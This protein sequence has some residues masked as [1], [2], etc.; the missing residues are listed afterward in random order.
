[1]LALSELN[2]NM[3]SYC[4]DKKMKIKSTPAPAVKGT[5]NTVCKGHLHQENTSRSKVVQC[6]NKWK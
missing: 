2:L 6:C 5:I 3:H 4:L 1:M